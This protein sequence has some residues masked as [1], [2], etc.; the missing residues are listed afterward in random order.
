MKSASAKKRFLNA[1]VDFWITPLLI[2]FFLNFLLKV[3][4]LPYADYRPTLVIITVAL[5]LVFECLYGRSL[6]KL[7][8]GTIVVTEKGEKPS[9]KQLVVRNFA[10]F[11]PFEALSYLT[12]NPV[13]WHDLLSKTQVVDVKGLTIKKSHQIAVSHQDS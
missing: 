7:V 12:K 11:I 1:V 5:V 9:L 6:G 3:G 13:G 10:R 2:S 8:S 4:Y